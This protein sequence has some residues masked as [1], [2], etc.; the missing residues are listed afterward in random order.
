MFGLRFETNSF[1]ILDFTLYR[2]KWTEIQ[3]KRPYRD[4][5]LLVTVLIAP[6]RDRHSQVLFSVLLNLKLF[7]KLA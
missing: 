5:N 4:E 6:K 3:N 1:L 2:K 7:L